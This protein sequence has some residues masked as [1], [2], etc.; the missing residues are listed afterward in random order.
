MTENSFIADLRGTRANTKIHVSGGYQFT[1][2]ARNLVRDWDA[3]VAELEHQTAEAKKW[4]ALA[5]KL[6]E[7]TD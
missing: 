2:S 7:L 5:L 1:G 6:A 4:K 3:L